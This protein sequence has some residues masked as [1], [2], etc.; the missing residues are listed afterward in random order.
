M[1]PACQPWPGAPSVPACCVESDRNSFVPEGELHGAQSVYQLAIWG[2]QGPPRATAH[3][4]RLQREPEPL[5]GSSLPYFPPAG[6]PVL[7]GLLRPSPS[8]QSVSTVSLPPLLFPSHGSGTLPQS[9]PS[10]LQIRLGHLPGPECHCGLAWAP[11]HLQPRPLPLPEA[12]QGPPR[13]T[14]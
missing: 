12:A 13:W 8:P 3:P 14:F 4:R 5:T 10:H 6:S 9:E 1:S 11:G 7:C 2:P